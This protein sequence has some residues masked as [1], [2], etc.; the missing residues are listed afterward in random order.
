[1]YSYVNYITFSGK[2]FLKIFHIFILKLS[3]VNST[4]CMPMPHFEI[5]FLLFYGFI[6]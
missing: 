5:Y 2:Y 3:K 4:V 6:L 1:M